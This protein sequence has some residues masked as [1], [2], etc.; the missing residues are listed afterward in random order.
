MITA[1]I[2]IVVIMIT[3]G[4]LI[5]RSIDRPLRRL[6]NRIGLIAKNADLTQRVEVE[7]AR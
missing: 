1:A 4:L 3:V 7:G 5:F 2:A 6:R